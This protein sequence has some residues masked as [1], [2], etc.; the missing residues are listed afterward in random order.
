[1]HAGE[2]QL[3]IVNHIVASVSYNQTRQ[4]KNS[5]YASV[6]YEVNFLLIPYWNSKLN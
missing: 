5:K 4:Y 3:E 2:V 6:L 1:M